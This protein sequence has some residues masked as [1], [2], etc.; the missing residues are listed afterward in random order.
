MITGLFAGILALLFL[1]LSAMVIRQRFARKVSLGNGGA[2]DFQRLIRT[3]ANFA[4]YVPMALILMF[5]YEM[6]TYIQTPWHL[7]IIG[8]A[9]V[10]ARGLHAWGLYKGGFYERVIGTSLTLLVI[11]ALAMMLIVK[12]VTA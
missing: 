10:V 1:F 5:L 2:E 8:G 11:F 6:Q 4:E 12:F 9:L 7:Y 3:H